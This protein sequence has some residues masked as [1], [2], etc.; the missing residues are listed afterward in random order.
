MRA[1]ERGALEPKP[2]ASMAVAS[3]VARRM[4]E[5]RFGWSAFRARFRQAVADV[6]IR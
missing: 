3:L 2:R 4:V 1:W 6:A 5:E